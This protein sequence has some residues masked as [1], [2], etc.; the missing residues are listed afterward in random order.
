MS[1]ATISGCAQE[2]DPI[3]RVGSGVVDKKFF[4]GN[5]A[6]SSDDPSFY[7]RN[8]VVDGSQSQS[9]VGIGTWSG[10]D[11]VRW[12]ITENMLFAR[13]AYQWIEGADDKGLA[14]G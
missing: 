14:E 11:R 13:K 12:E 1:T 9:L 4:V 2:R 7:W 6:D 8:Y 3:I 10:V 5:L